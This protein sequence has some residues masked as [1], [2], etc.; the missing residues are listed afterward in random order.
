MEGA[1]RIIVTI[2]FIGLVAMAVIFFAVFGIVPL[3]QIGKVKNGGS[4]SEPIIINIE[5]GISNPSTSSGGNEPANSST[6]TGGTTNNNPSSTGGT[7][8]ETGGSQTT[9]ETNPETEGSDS[10]VYVPPRVVRLDV[11]PGHPDAPQQSAPIS[12]DQL[13]EGAIEIVANNGKLS[14][15]S[16]TIREGED[17]ILA[18][19]SGDGKTHVLFFKDPSVQGIAIGIGAWETR[20]ISVRA[21]S[22][23]E[24]RFACSVPG[25]ESRGE[26]GVMKAVK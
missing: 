8:T 3:S 20:T 5:G 7:S 2:F 15:A 23:G 4:P 21:T 17:T 25:H 11:P 10:P 24:Y 26:K 6:T 22:A 9:P 19:T 1:L 16:F 13:P 14:P 12:R 18:F